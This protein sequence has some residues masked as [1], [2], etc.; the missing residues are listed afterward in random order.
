MKRILFLLCTSCTSFY[1]SCIQP[2][3]NEPHFRIA[4]ADAQAR[5]SCEEMN[6]GSYQ[7]SI[8]DGQAA[9]DAICNDVAAA[10]SDAERT[11]IAGEYVAYPA[12]QINPNVR[13]PRN[14]LLEL[15]PYE[16]DGDMHNDALDMI[17][18]EQLDGMD[19]LNKLM[20]KDRATI[21]KFLKLKPQFQ[22]EAVRNAAVNVVAGVTVSDELKERL[23]KIVNAKDY[24]EGISYLNISADAKALVTEVYA[25]CNDYYINKAGFELVAGYLNGKITS[26]LNKGKD[27]KAE[28]R[29][30]ARM[31]TVLKHSYYYWHGTK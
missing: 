28:D 29:K 20:N 7:Q 11:A 17:A 16:A 10:A 18:R 9:I 12:N 25:T 30:L 21:D 6:E 24:A 22:D 31:F 4:R 14:L 26:L 5:V 13:V 1:L 27:M 19:V 15:N 2:N 8:P 23:V 3:E